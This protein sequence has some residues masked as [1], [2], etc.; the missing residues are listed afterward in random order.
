MKVLRTSLYTACLAVC[1]AAAA[2]PASAA[3][4]YKTIGFETPYSFSPIPNGLGPNGEV[5]GEFAVGLEG[6]QWDNNGKIVDTFKLG[7]ESYPHVY[8]I[9]SE[10][11]A[12]VEFGTINTWL[13]TK[14]QD[15]LITPIDFNIN[16]YGNALNRHGH[17]VGWYSI[18]GTPQIPRAFFWVAG[19]LTDLGVL[20]GGTQSSA[21]AINSN[22][23]IAGNATTADGSVHAVAWRN[24]AMI[25]LGTL[26]GYT[27]SYAMN[28]SETGD[29]VGLSV[30]GNVAR[31]FRWSNGVMTALTGSLDIAQ[32]PIVSLYGGSARLMNNAGHIVASRK[33]NGRDQAVLWVEGNITELNPILGSISAE[34]KG[35]ND[36][37]QILAGG[38]KLIPI[39]PDVDVSVL[40]YGPSQVYVTAG[41]SFTYSVNVTNSGSLAATG[42]NLTDTLPAGVT[43]V[44]ATT[45]QGYCNGT[46][47][48][49][50]ALGSLATGASANI[51]ITVTPVSGTLVNTASVT[52]V[53]TDVNP[54]NNNSSYSNLVSTPVTPPPPPDVTADLGVTMTDS[55]DPVKRRSNLT[56]SIS[57]RNAGP[58]NASNVNVRDVLPSNMTFVSSRSSQGSCSGSSTVSCNLGTLNSGSSATVT[59]VVQPRNIGT[60]T[61]NV[62]V[63][64]TTSESSTTNNTATAV[65]TVR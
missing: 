57:V 33:V 59:I 63:S 28:I 26:S 5:A 46:T 24:G 31:P 44:S 42:V 58:A 43:F 52:S 36:A 37:G 25:D 48:V 14:N 55:P 13:W 54:L 41:Q 47:V 51:Q 27:H 9:N 62:S 53:E 29:V 45:S 65:T 17:V 61:N 64:T 49:S 16:N 23:D 4:T 38:R 3:T 39:D 12:L 19:Q 15:P 1:V 7:A 8:A 32:Y 20:P 50:C 6:V 35:I 18:S 56:Y 21:V 30:N 34:A 10:G 60:Y 22:G 40:M 11:Q 2:L